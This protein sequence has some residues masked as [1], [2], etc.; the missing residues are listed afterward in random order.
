[1]S[2]FAPKPTN[3]ADPNANT[4]GKRANIGRARPTAEQ[5]KTD[6]EARGF[7]S[8]IPTAGTF[9]ATCEGLRKFTAPATGIEYETLEFTTQSPNGKVSLFTPNESTYPSSVER[10]CRVLEILGSPVDA[11]GNYDQESLKGQKC[12]V[13][14][15]LD[16]SGKARLKWSGA[17]VGV[18]PPA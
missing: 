4:G 10:F 2:L 8:F 14:I 11:D 7:G 18:L 17:S 1:M 12:R 13:E 9:D 3:P 15:D 6:N 16:K 5:I